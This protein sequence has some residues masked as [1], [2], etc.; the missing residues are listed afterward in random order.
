MSQGHLR[1]RGPCGPPPARCKC[2]KGARRCRWT[3]VM[4][5]GQDPATGRPKYKWR[6][7]YATKAEA[8]SALQDA[9][10]AWKSGRDP[11]GESL[12]VAEFSQLWL[13][14]LEST[15]KVRPRTKANYAGLL[16][17]HVVPRLG[18]LEVRKVKPVHLQSILDAMT[19]TG[20]K[21]RT[22]AHARAC[23]SAMFSHAVRMQV[24]DTNPARA[25]TAPA[26]SRPHL[27]VPSAEQVRR[28]IDTA[29]GTPWEIPVLLAATT[30]A[31]RGEI[32]ALRWRNVD[33]DKERI[34]IVESL[35]RIDHALT[36]TPPKTA[37]SVRTVPLPGWVAERLAVHRTEQASRLRGLGQ[38]QKVGDDLVVCD[39][40]DG[41]PH[42]PDSFGHAVKRITERAGVPGARL[43]DLRHGVATMLASSGARAELTSKMLGHASVA[44]T[45]QTYTHPRDD[46]LIA[47]ADTI[48]SALG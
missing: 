15:G 24:L 6:G 42:D 8:A 26:K 35:Q 12:C 14:H 37:R 11:F 38:R 28:I 20:R 34:R 40:G 46:E 27:V 9:L 17:E 48:G 2:P 1:R 45:L 18:F 29:N 10:G 39:R 31:R 16:R 43:H 5:V 13:Q 25:T 3:Y 30:G 32:L 41:E 23:L 4:Y 36:F 22:V 44:F 7:G 21:P 19:A 33:L 47:L